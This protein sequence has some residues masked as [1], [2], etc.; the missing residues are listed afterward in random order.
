MDGFDV[1]P[2]VPEVPEIPETPDI[3]ETQEIPETMDVV[4][5]PDVT[6]TADVPELT[7]A[8]YTL[9]DEQA[10]PLEGFPPPETWQTGKGDEIAQ[11]QWSAG[12]TAAEAQHD[13]GQ[14]VELADRPGEAIAAMSQAAGA[15]DA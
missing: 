2:D 14:A 7:A 9:T 6:E 3:P 4:E 8:G 5:A 12:I 11:A 10:A 1:P 15:G 13:A